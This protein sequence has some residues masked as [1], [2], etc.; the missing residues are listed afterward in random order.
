MK[1]HAEFILLLPLLLFIIY[2]I[3]TYIVSDGT[4]WLPI[5]LPF[6]SGSH[7]SVLAATPMLAR[8]PALASVPTALSIDATPTTAPTA[9]PKS[10]LTVTPT[11]AAEPTQTFTPTLNPTYTASPTL[12]PIAGTSV[13]A[14]L[15]QYCSNILTPPAEWLTI[16]SPCEMVTGN[17]VLAYLN[18]PPQGDGNYLFN[19]RLDT[20]QESFL[21]SG[22]DALGDTLHAEITPADQPLINFPQVGMHILVVG[23]WVQNA[24]RYNWNEFHPVWY[25]VEL[26]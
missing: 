1:K 6:V 19:L 12:T 2:I 14:S 4:R 8:S 24:E 11:R 16:L 20:G 3:Y 5:D 15:R 18:S 23:A 10:T 26:P 21:S 9:T 7:A 25:W 22:N 13:P 17:V